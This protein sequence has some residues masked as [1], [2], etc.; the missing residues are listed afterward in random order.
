MLVLIAHIKLVD[1]LAFFMWLK[2]IGCVL[3]NILNRVKQSAYILWSV[4]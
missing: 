4:L 3:T 1:R 2:M